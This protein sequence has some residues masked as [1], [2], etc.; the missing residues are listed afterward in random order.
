MAA[1]EGHS[2]LVFGVALSA[3]GRLVASGSVHPDWEPYLRPAGAAGSL[4]A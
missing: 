3:D 2:G 1:L 4:S